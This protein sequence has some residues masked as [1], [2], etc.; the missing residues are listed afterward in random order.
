MATEKQLDGTVAVF[1]IFI[2]IVFVGTLFYVNGS[3]FPP[4]YPRDKTE[5]ANWSDF[6]LRRLRSSI[7][8][9][10]RKLKTLPANNKFNEDAR[11]VYNSCVMINRA[12]YDLGIGNN[13]SGAREIRK[14]IEGE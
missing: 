4:Q 12:I 13:I 1:V 3:I 11:F 8:C 7:D 14:R 2:C 9:K 5:L 10:N 6:D